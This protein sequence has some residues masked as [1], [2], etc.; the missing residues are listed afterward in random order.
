MI[1]GLGCSTTPLVRMGLEGTVHRV[2]GR[3]NVEFDAEGN[4][5]FADAFPTK[6]STWETFSRQRQQTWSAVMR[7]NRCVVWAITTTA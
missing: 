5:Y 1:V 6:S 3:R 4:M 7:K 2:D